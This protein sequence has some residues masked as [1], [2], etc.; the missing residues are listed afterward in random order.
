MQNKFITG[1]T[2]LVTDEDSEYFNTKGTIVEIDGDE[3][4]VYFS[5][6]D[7]TDYFED[8]QLKGLE[9]PRRAITVTRTRTREFVEHEETMSALD[10]LSNL[11]KK[12]LSPATK[13]MLKAGWLDESLN[14]TEEGTDVVIS[15]YF[16][17]NEE[18]FGKLA[19][20]FLKEKKEEA[21]K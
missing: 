1:E 18:K 17:E 15:E 16:S 3:V 21:K 4:A 10:K 5:E 14:L 6:E 19:A 13:N 11:T 8:Y 12:L 7:E 9:K 2:V 20:E